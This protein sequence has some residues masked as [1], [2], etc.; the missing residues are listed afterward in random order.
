MTIGTHPRELALG[1]LRNQLLISDLSKSGVTSMG[2]ELAQD[3][4]ITLI[5]R[6]RGSHYLIYNEAGQ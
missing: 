6:A 5:T 3:L 1:F 4:G 2:L